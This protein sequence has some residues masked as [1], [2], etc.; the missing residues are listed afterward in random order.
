MAA[1]EDSQQHQIK[2]LAS[3]EENV[4]TSRETAPLLRNERQNI[5]LR[6]R[7][8]FHCRYQRCCVSSK[9]ALLIFV[10]NLI[11]VADFKGFLDPKLNF[12]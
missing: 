5:R 12:V 9:A 3:A 7:S 2:D 11:L 8:K 4:P 6:M 1:F 10:W